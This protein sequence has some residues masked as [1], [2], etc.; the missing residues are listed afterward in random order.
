MG[1]SE[2]EKSLYLRPF[3]FASEAFLGVRSAAKVTFCLIASPVGPY[4]PSGL[5]PVSI[6]LSEEYTRAAPGGTGAAKCAGNYAA[7]LV[8]IQEA[9]ANGCDQAAFL[10][11]VERRWIEELGGM[12]LY[13]VFDDGSIVTPSSPARFSRASPASR[14]SPWPARPVARSRSAASTSTSGA[15]ACSPAASQRCSPVARPPS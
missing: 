12:N 13:F 1:P 15:T 9:Q 10:D 8:A 4:F 2:G 7:S 5:K 3:M 11:A 6:W 14:S